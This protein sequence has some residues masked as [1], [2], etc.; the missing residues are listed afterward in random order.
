MLLVAGLLA[1]LAGCTTPAPAADPPGTSAPAPV[2][3]PA[4]AADAATAR[5]TAVTALLDRWGAAARAGDVDAVAALLDPRADPAFAASERARTQVLGTLELTDL[6]YRIGDGLAPVVDPATTAALG[7]DE[8]WAPPVELHYALAGADPR[9]TTRPVGL[10][11]ARR[12]ASWALVSDTAV[13]DRGRATW[14]GPWDFGPLLTRRGAAGGVV[15]A[16]PAQ[17]AA[18]ELLGGALDTAVGAVTGFWGPGWSQQA[19]VWVA[20]S[21]DELRALVGGPVSNASAAVTTADSV[22]RAAGTAT[23]QRVVISP[24]ALDRLTPVTAGVLL[25]HE[26]SH[27]ATRARTSEQAPLWLLE[28]VAQYVGYRGTGTTVAVGAPRVAALV[29]EYGPP[30]QLPTDVDFAS[31]PGV[32]VAYQLAWTFGAFV[33]DTRGEDALRRL[34]AAVG[35]LV[36]PT[37]AELD[38]AVTPVLGAPLAPARA[39]WGG[40]LA[41]RLG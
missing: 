11:V 18:L 19:A 36:T 31:G 7:A 34:Q 24:A 10:V 32:D 3:A 26:L 38:A 40:W 30:D 23:G 5:A 6:G 21:P 25:R 33:A 28:G 13:A 12:G 17:A 4:P 1:P 29:A 15:L 20:G 37:E 35:V 27:A 41:A 22:D 39:E 14:R 2:T 9:P 16:H 8:V